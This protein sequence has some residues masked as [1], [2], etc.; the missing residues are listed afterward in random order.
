MRAVSSSGRRRFAA[1]F[2]RMIPVRADRRPASMPKPSVARESGKGIPVDISSLSDIMPTNFRIPWTASS[3]TA[4]TV[5]CPEPAPAACGEI[6]VSD[7]RR[8]AGASSP[9]TRP[10]RWHG[11]IEPSSRRGCP[12]GRLTTDGARK[13]RADS[14]KSAQIADVAEQSRGVLGGLRISDRLRFP[15]FPQPESAPSCRD[16]AN[17]SSSRR[18]CPPG[19][20]AVGVSPGECA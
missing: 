1:G 12:S 9:M 19:I 17:A 16:G 3:R 8:E 11:A 10:G 13:G 18:G 15:A 20:V 4:D 5:D 2:R 6:G 7:C 14:F